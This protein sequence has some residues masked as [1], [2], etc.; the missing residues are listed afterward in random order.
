MSQ[1]QQQQSQ[2]DADGFHLFQVAGLEAP[3][4]STSTITPTGTREEVLLVSWI[5]LLLQS[6][7][8]G[9]VR[10]EWAYSGAEKS[11]LSTPQVMPGLQSTIGQVS[12]AVAQHIAAATQDQSPVTPTT[13]LLSTGTL[14][15]AP[16]EVKDT[17]N[18]WS[19][20]CEFKLTNHREP[21]CHP[22]GGWL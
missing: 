4:T 21:G 14:S 5:I 2:V 7:E 6:C 3:S 17:V 11:S 13:L 19:R 9:Q 12:A 1:Q 22:C 20:V 18:H 15:Q 16:E 10:F 8:D